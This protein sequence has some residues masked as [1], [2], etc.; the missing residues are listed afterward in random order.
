M[1][2][3]ASNLSRLDMCNRKAWVIWNPWLFSSPTRKHSDLCQLNENEVNF[4]PKWKC[5]DEE[6][7][8]KNQAESIETG[9]KKK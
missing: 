5:R 4:G 6:G 8:A 1:S 9:L 2:N 3:T 7:A